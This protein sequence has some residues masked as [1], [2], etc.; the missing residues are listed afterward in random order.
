M[1]GT[2]APGLRIV[3]DAASSQGEDLRYFWLQT[4]G[5]RVAIPRPDAARVQVLVP[6]EAAELAFTLIVAGRAGVDRKDVAVPLLLHETPNLPDAELTADAGDDQT[7][8]V[9]H[10]VTLNGARSMPR[11]GLAYR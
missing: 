9:G 4:K 3:L 2:A 8:I 10:R 6:G 11:E 7:A 5:P 1:E